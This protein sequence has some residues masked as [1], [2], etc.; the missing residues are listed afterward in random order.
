M[1]AIELN[2]NDYF[3]PFMHIMISILLFINVGIIG[4]YYGSFLMFFYGICLPNHKTLSFLRVLSMS[5]IFFAL[6]GVLC[7][8]VCLI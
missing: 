3:K 7:F 1:E 2:F 8:G 6:I 5:G 4:V